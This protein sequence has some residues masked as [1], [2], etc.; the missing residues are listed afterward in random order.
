MTDPVTAGLAF[1]MARMPWDALADTLVAFASGLEWS[2]EGL[3]KPPFMSALLF[4]SS[5]AVSKAASFER[6]K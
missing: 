4:G 1:A 3:F 5:L 6:T 2:A